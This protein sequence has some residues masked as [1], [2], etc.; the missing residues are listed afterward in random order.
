MYI[1]TNKF[2]QNMFV[3][4]SFMFSQKVV[5]KRQNVLI[6]PPNEE[7]KELGSS[8]KIGTKLMA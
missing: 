7:G 1:E 4:L 2:Y 3:F 6:A 5:L 8:Q